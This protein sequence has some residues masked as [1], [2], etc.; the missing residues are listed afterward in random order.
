MLLL[1]IRLGHSDLK[2]TMNVYTH[3]TQKA[4]DDIGKQFSDYI[5]F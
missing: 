3:I 4:I 2:T 5:D 1:F